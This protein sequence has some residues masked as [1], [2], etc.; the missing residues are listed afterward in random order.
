MYIPLYPNGIA[1]RWLSYQQ[2]VLSWKATSESLLRALFKR[3]QVPVSATESVVNRK[4]P[5]ENVQMP[6]KP[7]LAS[8]T[9]SNIWLVVTGTMEFW[10]TFQK[11][12]GMECHHPNWRTPSFFKMVIAPPTRCSFFKALVSVANILIFACVEY[13]SWG[14]KVGVQTWDM[15]W[16]TPKLH[17]T[18]IMT[19]KKR[20]KPLYLMVF[21]HVASLFSLGVTCPGLH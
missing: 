1:I 17:K 11:Q 16:Y 6:V 21:S 10:M 19:N 2:R 7:P 20:F 18:A 14:F 12:L 8:W 5:W 3:H 9:Q 4:S 15:M 13:N